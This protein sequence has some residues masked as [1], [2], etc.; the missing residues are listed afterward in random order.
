M[1]HK[2][3]PKDSDTNEIAEA[4]K[5]ILNKL[6]RVSFLSFEK[7]RFSADDYSVF[8]N[9]VSILAS[10]KKTSCMRTA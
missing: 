1:Y 9:W 10:H 7:N 4:D 3:G 8:L 6:I 5:T 2:E